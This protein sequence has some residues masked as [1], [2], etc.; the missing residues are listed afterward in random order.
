MRATLADLAKRAEAATRY[1][2]DR[3]APDK[4]R[5]VSVSTDNIDPNE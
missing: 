4:C 3:S 1:T 2:T 5:K